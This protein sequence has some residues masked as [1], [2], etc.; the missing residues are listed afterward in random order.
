MTDSLP[1]KQIPVTGSRGGRIW[2]P[3]DV[4]GVVAFLPGE[5]AG[6]LNPVEIPIDYGFTARAQ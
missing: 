1:G 5:D 2:L 6:F 3:G 4:A